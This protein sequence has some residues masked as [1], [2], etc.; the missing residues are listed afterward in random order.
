MRAA[1]A[2]CR[3][4]AHSSSIVKSLASGVASHRLPSRRRH[5]ITAE[6]KSRRRVGGAGI[7]RSSRSTCGAAKCICE[8][9]KRSTRRSRR[10]YRGPLT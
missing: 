6:K 2:R 3:S 4:I 5:A 9:K 10:S 8:S 7:E 1:C